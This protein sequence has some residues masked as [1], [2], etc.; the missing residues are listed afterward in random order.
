MAC[1]LF[2]A[3]PLF[4]PMIY[5]SIRPQWTYYNE[6]LFEIQK[7]LFMNYE[8]IVCEKAAILYQPQYVYPPNHWWVSEW[9]N[10]MAFLGTADSEVHIVY[11]SRVI[12][13]YTLES[14][15]SLT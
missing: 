3:K 4:E 15:S 9:L 14:L 7:F 5:C 13:A 12:T 1:L 2:S 6:I 11:V 8:N 10:S